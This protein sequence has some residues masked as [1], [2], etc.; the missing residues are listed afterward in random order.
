MATITLHSMT[1]VKRQDSISHDEIKVFVGGSIVGGPFGV[2]KGDTVNLGI[3]R[4]FSSATSVQLKEWDSNSDEDN[5]GTRTVGVNAITHG[6]L[7]FDAAKNAYYTVNYS[8]AA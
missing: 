4:T 3:V 6:N 5:L 7:I 8:V 1:C 2:D